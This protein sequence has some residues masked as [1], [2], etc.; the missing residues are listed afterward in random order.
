MHVFTVEIFNEAMFTQQNYSL[1]LS[2]DILTSQLVRKLKVIM[3]IKKQ[4]L[5]FGSILI[6]HS[7]ILMEE[8]H[9][10]PPLLYPGGAWT[11]Q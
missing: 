11:C 4:Q 7:F 3:I 1:A 9:F 10:P 2:F 8:K 6:W 5:V